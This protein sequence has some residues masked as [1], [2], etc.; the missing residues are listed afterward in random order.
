MQLTA[1]KPY[2]GIMVTELNQSPPFASSAFY[3]HL[4]LRGA[5]EGIEVFVFS[6]NRIDWQQRTVTGYHYDPEK[7]EWVKKLLPLPSLIYDR[8]FFK[9]RASFKRYQS[10]VNKLRAEPGHQFL[11]YGLRGKWDVQQ[12]LRKDAGLRAFLPE[13]RKLLN[14][15]ILR[16]CLEDKADVFLKPEG[17]SQGKG[18]LHIH[19]EPSETSGFI[20]ILNGRD[21]RNQPV[22]QQFDNLE[23]LWQWL[24]SWIRNRPY[25][26]QEYLSLHTSTGKSFDVRS[27]VQKNGQ[28]RWQ[29]TGMA[30]R[31]GKP[32]SITSNLHG[33]G[34]AAEIDEF[35]N[36]EFGADKAKQIKHVIGDLSQRIPPLLE[37]HHGRLVEL[38]IDLGIDRNSRVWILEVNSKPGRSI[39]ARM[40]DQNARA[41][42]IV[43]PIRYAKYLWFGMESPKGNKFRRVT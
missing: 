5:E 14:E 15:R 9:G 16:I 19:K 42:S 30:V 37:S 18:T 23:P 1:M 31:C 43:N 12:M 36:L 29:T 7:K 40:Q 17:G 38:G 6:P 28:G 21:S 41:L 39:F 35:L 26:I 34:T 8:C 27:L 20:Y 4:I 13:T 25:L 24:R 10:V 11:G 22:M 2:L 3:K 32:G 33:G